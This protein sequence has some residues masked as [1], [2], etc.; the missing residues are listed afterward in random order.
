MSPIWIFKFCRFKN[1]VNKLK[2]CAHN[3][4]VINLF[5]SNLQSKWVGDHAQEDLAKFG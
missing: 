5:F 2:L 3:I 1:Q 4:V